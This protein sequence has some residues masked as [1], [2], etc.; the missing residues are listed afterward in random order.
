MSIAYHRTAESPAEAAAQ[1]REDVDAVLQDA[2]FLRT[3]SGL[4]RVEAEA[5]GLEPLPWLRAQEDGAAVYWSDREQEFVAA[6]IGEAA[7]FT[8]DEPVS[9]SELFR[10]MRA[11][12]KFATPNLRIY[13]G[14]RFDRGPRGEGPWKEYGAYRFSAPL[15]EVLKKGSRSYLACNLDLDALRE[16]GARENLRADFARLRFESP[17]TAN[18]LPALISR[19]ESPER[20]RWLDDVKNLLNTFAPGRLRKVVLARES[21][22]AFED[23]LDPL[24]IFK[25]LADSA[26]HSYRYILRP[27]VG[28]A[29]IGASPERLFKRT[30][31]A[32][33]S[34]ALAG[35]RPRGATPEEDAVLAKEL[36]SSKK[37]LEE[38]ALVVDQIRGVIEKHCRAVRGGGRR[39]RL[40]LRHCQHLLTRLEGM[41]REP[42]D[43]G[44]ILDELHPTPAMGGVPTDT[45]MEAIKRIEN[46]DRGWYTGPVGW[47]SRHE[48]EFAAAIRS[49][50]VHG[51]EV[52]VYAGAGI[53]PASEPEAELREIENKL[54]DFENILARP[55]ANGR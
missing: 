19:E 48:T 13:G 1:L 28:T 17:A 6:G 47:L 21:R 24:T 25:R 40:T 18:D 54:T 14:F 3:R 52:R 32:L 46:F 12:L 11:R 34:E 53:V 15:F 37:E 55:G 5:P 20:G 10:T 51:N 49:G 36:N 22:F 39:E 26:T 27:R 42:F 41:L 43:D 29:F 35:T 45:A 50:L 44:A 38:H 2:E 33:K 23:T 8:S 31:T 16:A 4:I 7:V 9:A 30:G